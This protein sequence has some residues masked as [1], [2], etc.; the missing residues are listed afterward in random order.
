MRP[1]HLCGILA[2]F[3]CITAAAQPRPIFDVDD[4][5]DPSHHDGPLFISRL[6]LGATRNAID[7]YRPLHDDAAFIH[8]ANSF[9]WSHFQLDY[10]HSEVRAESDPPGVKTCG[11]SPPIYFPTPPPRDG[12]PLPPHPGSK[13]VV[14]F[15]WYPRSSLRY[16]LSWS[17]Q[18]IHT[19][20][21]SLTTGRILSRVSGDEQSFALDGDTHFRVGGRDV[22]GSLLFARTLRSG[23]IDDRGQNEFLYLSRFPARLLGPVIVQAT[24][25]AGVV[26]G[27]GAAG[28]NVVNPALEVFWHEPRTQTNLHVVW[29][30]Q[31]ARSGVGGWETHH[32]IAVFVDRALIVKLFSKRS[33]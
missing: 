8:V 6:I 13:D 9:Y 14:R 10:G 11:C 21:V 31:S 26:T 33:P 19:D 17:R 27:R 12:T 18:A 2:L 20:L 4:F 24:L 16:Q 28:L 32:Q 5:V 15:G 22:W 3:A 29:S 25:A 7:D 30:P 23:T 1:S